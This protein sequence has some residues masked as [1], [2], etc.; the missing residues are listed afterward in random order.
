[1]SRF[2]NK[3]RA[4]P[5]ARISASV[6]GVYYSGSY[7][8]LLALHLVGVLLLVGPLALA[9]AT[10]ARAVRA[11]EPAALHPTLRLVRVLSAGSVLVVLLGLAMLGRD[12]PAWELSNSWVLAS[13]A[14]WFVAVGLA[15]GVVVPALRSAL[16]EAEKGQSSAHLAAQ[17]GAAG[18]LSTLCW[19][20]IV[21]LM[22]Y[23]PG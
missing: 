15:S 4:V 9:T 6:G 23:K 19:V 11:G 16:T 8:V 3:A 5:R 2:G 10:A 1:M 17:V 12:V 14:L 20:A 13:L 18:G 22:V 7:A 21:V